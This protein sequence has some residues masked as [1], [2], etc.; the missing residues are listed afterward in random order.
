M[1]GQ[2]P[3]ENV[4]AYQDILRRFKAY[5]LQGWQEVSDLQTCGR[6]LLALSEACR[7]FLRLETGAAQNAGAT[8]VSA[9]WDAQYLTLFTRFLDAAPTSGEHGA[10]L[11]SEGVRFKFA[12]AAV[13]RFATVVLAAESP[14]IAPYA[15][16]HS[17]LTEVRPG[18]VRQ[19][20]EARTEAL[21]S[22]RILDI[23]YKPGPAALLW[24]AAF[25]LS[26]AHVQ[27]IW[28]HFGP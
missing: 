2:D 19:V 7:G 23:I 17:S 25:D 5:S 3:Y 28:Q 18:L 26:P 13:S 12:G 20:I 22:R 24:H 16:E 15:D 9:E 10:L 6:M 11:V 27:Q 8:L 4:A 1:A 21:A 14:Y